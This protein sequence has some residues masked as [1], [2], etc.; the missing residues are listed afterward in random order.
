MGEAES[1]AEFEADSEAE[2]ETE[3]EAESVAEAETLSE[4]APLEL[5]GCAGASVI[6]ETEKN[7]LARFLRSVQPLVEKTPK[8]EASVAQAHVDCERPVVL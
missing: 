4:M 1:E 6:S 3:S 8:A 2:F 7:P 5:A